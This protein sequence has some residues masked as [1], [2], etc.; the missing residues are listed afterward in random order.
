MIAACP[1]PAPDAPLAPSLLEAADCHVQRLVESGYNAIFPASGGLTAVL[2][3]LLTI[4]VALIGFRLMLGQGGLR[5]NDVTINVVK[6][7]AVLALATQWNVYQQ[8]VYHL[9]FQGPEQLASY[10]RAAADEGASTQAMVSRLQEAFESLTN[11]AAAYGAQSPSQVS[12]LVGGAGFG[13]LLLNLAAMVLILSS[14]GVLLAAK[15]V[16]GVLLAL[17]PLFIALFLF[18]ATRGLTEGWLRACLA[19]AIVPLAVSLLLSV[20]LAMLE[21]ALAGLAE[22]IAKK[23]FALPPVY[24]TLVIVMVF[25]GVV[26]G[27]II[28]SGLIA[29]GLRLPQR[30]TTQAAASSNPS[31]YVASPAIPPSRADQLSSIVATQDRR[32]ELRILGQGAP[33]AADVRP[34][35]AREPAGPGWDGPRQQTSGRRSMAPKTVR[36]MQGPS[37]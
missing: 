31:V 10:L 15:I 14:V 22:T 24:F 4:Y 6:L 11:A 35:G 3:S 18:D 34:R 32:E 19:F 21:P 13:A 36:S 27:A 28:A 8:V 7:G 29:T 20:N 5:L 9:L 2:T 1:T 33:R 25:S 26:L 17:G 37:Q 12:P 30:A 23:Q 16:L